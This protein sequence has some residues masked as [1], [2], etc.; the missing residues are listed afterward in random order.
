MIS[1]SEI[2]DLLM[3]VAAKTKRQ[4]PPPPPPPR[5]NDDGLMMAPPPPPPPPRL[6]LGRILVKLLGTDGVTPT[7]LA[8][9]L[10]IRLPSLS[11]AIKKLESK[12]LVKRKPFPESKRSYLIFLT[13][14]GRVKAQKH[15]IE[16]DRFTSEFFKSIS[17]MEKIQLAEILEKLLQGS[18][19]E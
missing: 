5:K 4:P 12:G 16:G 2:M 7:A 8:E 15:K 18:E 1:E 11:E 13:A 6:G 9:E 14:T 10:E 19:K 3:K 17:D